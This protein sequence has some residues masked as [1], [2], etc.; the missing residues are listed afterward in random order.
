M[1]GHLVIADISGYTQFLTESELDH[2]NGI[3]GDLLSAIIG[4]IQAPLAVSSI[5]GD[6]V[7]MYGQAPD[8]MS[9]QAII[10]SV[11]LLYG[12]FAGALERMVLNTTCTCNACVNI[13]S[14]GLKIVMHCGEYAT[15]TVAGITT[16]SGPDVIAVHRL[17]KNRVV[18][19]TGIQD[20]LMVTQQCVDDLGIAPLVRSWKAHTETYDHVGE[21]AGYVSSL[22]EAWESE[23][24]RTEV[25]VPLDEAW[26]SVEAH[27]AAPP[28]IVW[29]HLI[30][31]AKRTQWI[32]VADDTAVEHRIAGRIGPGT[33]YHCAHG[34]HEVG[35]FTILDMRTNA[36]CTVMSEFVDGSFLTYTW[37]L[38][39][40][41]NG[42]ML[43]MACRAPHDADG[44]TVPALS[45]EDARA[46][47]HAAATANA[48]LLVSMTDAA[49]SKLAPA[50]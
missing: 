7:F 24:L 45:S 8:D 30:D 32:A 47:W 4:A 17:L 5:E 44:H 23:R 20:Y 13:R 31:P 26:D 27:T 43:T 3:V 22:R 10:E 25:A 50:P 36:Y 34:D 37:Y 15:T 9:G 46:G 39:A 38:R 12:G 11:E 40:V 33:E 1:K 18:E 49:A 41:E 35:V 28:T 19:E 48:G 14:L 6:A 16:L 21:I 42:T 2:A 29:D